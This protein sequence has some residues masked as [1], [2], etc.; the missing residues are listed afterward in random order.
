MLFKM[1]CAYAIFRA[2]FG[3]TYTKIGT[4]Q[5]RL[6]WPLRKD[7]TQIREAFQIFFLSF[8]SCTSLSTPLFLSTISFT[9]ALDTN[10]ASLKSI[11]ALIAEISAAKCEKPVRAMLW[12][13][14]MADASIVLRT[15]TSFSGVSL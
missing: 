1:R 7:D 15:Q 4:I 3:G 11:Q 5:R 8:W 10:R 9:V 14:K 13:L 12:Q 2:H 6:A